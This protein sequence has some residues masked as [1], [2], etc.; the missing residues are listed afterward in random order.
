VE[1]TGRVK[2]GDVLIAINGFYVHHLKY[3][4][5]VTLLNRN[6]PYLYLRFLRI[7]ACLE[8]RMS[9]SVTD[10]LDK[11]MRFTSLKRYP[12]RSLFKGV[13]P[14]C[15][16]D[17][18]AAASTV[19]GEV[20]VSSGVEAMDEE[21]I[22]SD[23]KKPES[24]SVKA[25]ASSL[26][27]DINRIQWVAEYVKD[28]AIVRIGLFDD[29]VTAARA[30]DAAVKSTMKV[31]SEKESLLLNFKDNGEP[32]AN[33]LPLYK[34]VSKERRYNKSVCEYDSSDE[35]GKARDVQFFKCP[36]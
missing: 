16:K 2:V 19:K 25:T 31:S 24:E 14:F 28:Y 18:A 9:G 21:K 35:V 36:L 13:Y 23:E 33:A 6:Q 7:P 3:S 26:D 32:S 1:A 27:F 11:K 34:E 4:N 22:S 5:I 15:L 30:Y 29:E 8:A 20:A 10:Y 17:L 12:I